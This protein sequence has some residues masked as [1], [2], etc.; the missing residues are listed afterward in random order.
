MWIARLR[1][2]HKDCIIRPR[3][4]R[5]NVSDHVQ[6]INS[7]TEESGF[8]YTEMHILQGEE[9]SVAEFIR[10]FRKDKSIIKFEQK[11]NHII[12]L[13]KKKALEGYYSIV[14]NHKLIYVKPVL[15]RT[16]GYEDWHIAC[17][18]KEPIM[19][20]MK[21]PTFDMKLISIQQAKYTDLFLP[22]LMP[23]LSP[24]QKEA[25]ELAVRE[26]Y[27]EFPKKTYLEDL[28]RTAKVKRQ[29]F[30]EHLSRA[31]KKLISFMTER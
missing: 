25:I 7:W 3:C 30:Q 15:Q 28:S 21:I 14:F 17:W 9:K 8:Y 23:K 27:Y 18:T 11:G 31:E 29:T 24:K 6:L 20:L 2:W 19:D 10:D 22:Q 16:D 12:T 26:G 13:N 5:Y 1:N 4:V